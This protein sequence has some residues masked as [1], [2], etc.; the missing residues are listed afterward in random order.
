MFLYTS[1]LI[2]ILNIPKLNC[3]ADLLLDRPFEVQNLYW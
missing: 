2:I 1:F 3:A